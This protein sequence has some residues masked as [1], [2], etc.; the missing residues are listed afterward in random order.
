METSGTQ[1]TEVR[2]TKHNRKS[3]DSGHIWNTRH[4]MKTKRCALSSFCVLCSIVRHNKLKG[5]SHHHYS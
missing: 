2:Q 4:R 5:F 3:R 1:E